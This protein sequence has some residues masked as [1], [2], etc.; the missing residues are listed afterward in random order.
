MKEFLPATAEELSD[1]GISR[2]DVIIVTGD[3]YIDSY[4]DGA[5]VIGRVLQDAGYTVGI[6]AQPDIHSADDITRLGEPRLFWGVT[7]GCVDSMV[8]NYTSLK[9]KKRFDDLTPEGQFHKRPDR[10]T[11]VYTNLIKRYFKSRKPVILGGVEASLRRIAHYDYWSDT[12]K[13]SVLLDSKADALVYGMGELTIL[14]LARKIN[15]NLDFRD[16]RGICFLGN[17]VPD[18]FLELP[19]YET[20]KD[21]KYKFIEMFKIF[22]ENNDPLNAVGLAQQHAARWLIQ[23]P[24]QFQPT[25]EEL[26]HFHSLGFRR[27]VHPYYSKQGRVKSLDTI[28]FSV[29]T[30]RGCYGECNFCAITVHQGRT[31]NSRSEASILSDIEEM[32]RHRHFK[33][34]ISDLGGPTANMYGNSCKKQQKTGSCKDKRCSFPDICKAMNIDHTKQ[35]A[36]LSRVR[37]IDKVKKAFIGS[38]IRYDLVIAD[39]KKGKEY[40]FDVVNHHVSGQLKIAPEHTEEGVLNYIGKPAK[41]YLKRF[42]D[43]FY[44]LTKMAGKKQFLTYYFIAAHPGCNMDDMYSLNDFIRTELRLTPEQVQIFN[45]TPSTYSSV[46]YW[47]E[48]DPWTLEKIFVEKNFKLKSKQKAVLTGVIPKP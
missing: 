7:A 39:A 2:L 37:D 38:G 28:Q 26:D 33:G 4:Y 40:F 1:S 27:E 19:S 10:A 44:S 20:V 31:I 5:A 23:N 17:N 9:K 24:P 34:I 3:V 45:P 32:K 11:I 29:N 14:E 36:L 30:H 41:R 46:M 6:I 8:A 35:I 48:L 16:T 15:H 42:K 18:G 13:R 47:T 22:Y 21:N 43:D 25:T 12:V